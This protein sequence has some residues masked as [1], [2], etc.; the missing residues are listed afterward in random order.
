MRR[1]KNIKNAKVQEGSWEKIWAEIK[2]WAYVDKK[3]TQA[4]KEIQHNS[5]VNYV[6]AP[7]RAS[8]GGT[9]ETI[10]K[11]VISQYHNGWFYFD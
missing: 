1:L 7:L 2:E 8:F 10:V 6:N 11:F 4:A 5:I 9:K 3:S